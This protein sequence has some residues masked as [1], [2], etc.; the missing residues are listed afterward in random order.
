VKY[1]C[2]A[3]GSGSDWEALSPRERDEFSAQDELIQRR[4]ALMAAVR[5]EEVVTVRAWD[6]TPT[7]TRG[8]FGTLSHALAGFSVI[9][10]DSVDEVV[11]LVTNT[12][13]ARAGGAIE[14][15]PILQI[16]E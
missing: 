8:P 10:A 3:Y 7:V 11:R 2:L 16:S 15:R 5:P 13:C 4:G 12:P 6:G 1:L 14:I 9:E